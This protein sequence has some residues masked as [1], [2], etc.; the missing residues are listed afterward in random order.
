MMKSGSSM[1]AIKVNDEDYLAVI[2][3]WGPS[4]NNTPK[5]PGAQ[6]SER[7]GNQLCNEVHMYRLKTDEWISPTVTGDR[8]PPI[9]NFSLSSITNTTAIL[10]GG[11]AGHDRPINDVYV[12]EFTKDSTDILMSGFKMIYA[13]M[14]I[15][16][17]QHY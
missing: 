5:Q 3:G 4:S 15:M 13:S 1:I 8:P 10:F 12:F 14:G 17:S 9:Y 2:G 16:H 7:Y 11:V 6:Y